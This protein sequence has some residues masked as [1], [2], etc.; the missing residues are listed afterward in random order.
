MAPEYLIR[1]QL[2][3]KADVYSFGVLVLEIVG[4]KRCNAFKEDSGSLLQTVR[5]QIFCYSCKS[6]FL[7]IRLVNINPFWT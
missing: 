3:E 4:G 7:C 5:S 6:M 2:T 1:G